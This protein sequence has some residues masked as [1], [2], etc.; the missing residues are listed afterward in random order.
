M[1]I[2]QTAINTIIAGTPVDVVIARITGN[3]IVTG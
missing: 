3:G 1:V 2:A